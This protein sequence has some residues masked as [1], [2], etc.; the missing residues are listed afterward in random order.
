MG[1]N[2]RLTIDSPDASSGSQVDN[3]ERIVADW[4]KEQFSAGIEK[5]AHWLL[6]SV[7]GIRTL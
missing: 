4:G 1:I 5:L 6:L 3:L 7:T 2:K